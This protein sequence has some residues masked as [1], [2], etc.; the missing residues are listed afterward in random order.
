MT[1]EEQ[2]TDIAAAESAYFES[3][4][5]TAFETIVV[6]Y[7]DGLIAFVY[8]LTGDFQLAEDVAQDCFA[9][10]WVNSRRFKGKSTLKTYLY[11]MAHNIAC[12]ALRKNASVT[13]DESMENYHSD[14]DP[15]SEELLTDERD[16]AVWKA[17]MA[18]GSPDRELIY[19]RYF[20][21]MRYEDIGRI[22]KL[23]T[24]K[25]YK[26]AERAKRSLAAELG[27]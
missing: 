26:I 2:G 22:L 19:L 5:R 12:C 3:G 20:E 15:V 18:L 16:R 25:L 17:L 27:V 4:D 14:K 9:N 21:Q 6:H 10:L 7:M 23:A 1:K 8:R 13:S 11:G 24:K